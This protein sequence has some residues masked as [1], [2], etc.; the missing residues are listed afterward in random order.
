[1]PRLLSPLERRPRAPPLLL[2]LIIAICRSFGDRN[3]LARADGLVIVSRRAAVSHAAAAAASPSAEERGGA[4]LPLL[5]LQLPL[6]L[7]LLR[8][9]HRLALLLLEEALRILRQL[10]EDCEW[11]LWLRDRLSETHWR[12][13]GVS[14]REGNRHAAANRRRIRT[15]ERQDG[16]ATR[17]ESDWLAG[18]NWL[19]VVVAKGDGLAGANRW[20]LSP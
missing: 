3:G 17:V 7:C 10:S 5:L 13:G 6:L 4:L 19:V 2:L 12:V 11:I 15:C 16:L 9:K 8:R 20:R 14:F 1:M 18:A